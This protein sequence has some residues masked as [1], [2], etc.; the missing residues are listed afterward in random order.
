MPV[1]ITTALK[2]V[3]RVKGVYGEDS[4]SE[5]QGFIDLMKDFK[6]GR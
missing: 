5:Y 3:E 1:D 2:F 6:G 4:Q